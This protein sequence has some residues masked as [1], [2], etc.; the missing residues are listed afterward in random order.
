VQSGEHLIEHAEGVGV[1]IDAAV[2]SNDV[3]LPGGC[4]HLLR[5]TFGRLGALKV[6]AQ[7]VVSRHHGLAGRAGFEAHVFEHRR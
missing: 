2:F 6:I 5:R 1:Q 3:A 4:D 7:P